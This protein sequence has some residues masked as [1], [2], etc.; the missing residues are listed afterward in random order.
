M[1]YIKT[2]KEYEEY[3]EKLRN[4]TD[5]QIEQHIGLE[6]RR[7]IMDGYP[8]NHGIEQ[9][10]I[11]VKE[12]REENESDKFI[13]GETHDELLC[14]YLKEKGI[15][16]DM[17]IDEKDF[18]EWLDKRAIECL[19]KEFPVKKEIREIKTILEMKMNKHPQKHPTH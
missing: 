7:N 13:T 6:R 11:L 18:S 2:I 10:K 17:E 19:M 15:D 3:K 1:N 14:N 16:I 4:M 9:L 5:E 8:E 12:L